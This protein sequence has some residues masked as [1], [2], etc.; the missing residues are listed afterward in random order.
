[1][2][3]GGAGPK[4]RVPYHRYAFRNPYNYTLM[5]GVTAASLLTGQAWLLIAGAAAEA[6]WMVFAPDSKLL[7]RL[8]FDRLHAEHEREAAR[9]ELARKLASLPA[10]DGERVARLEDKR[11]RLLELARENQVFTSELMQ[12]ELAKL[13]KLVRDF[14]ELA[15]A[16]HRHEEYLED[17]D[18]RALAADLR[19]HEALTG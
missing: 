2:A 13:E 11:A 15:V 7:R 3:A 16:V 10:A 14:A 5:A 19:R 12:S 4:A 1:M 6:L 9:Q 8:W 17:A 18:L